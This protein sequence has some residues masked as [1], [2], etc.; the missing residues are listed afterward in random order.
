MIPY[1]CLASRCG[2]P[3]A[4]IRVPQACQLSPIE[5]LRLFT[6]PKRFTK[7]SRALSSSYPIS[8]R[9]SASQ[10]VEESRSEDRAALDLRRG[11]SPPYRDLDGFFLHHVPSHD[12]SRAVMV[13]SSHNWIFEEEI[14]EL[15]EESGYA[16]YDISRAA[17][18]VNNAD[19][20]RERVHMVYDDLNMTPH[21]HCVVLSSPK[22]AFA[23]R[24]ELSG[25]VFYG[26]CVQIGAFLWIRR[27]LPR[28]GAALKW[29]WYANSS[30]SFGHRKLRY[31]RTSPKEGIFDSF[32]EGRHVVFTNLPVFG[33]HT[34]EHMPHIDYAFAHAYNVLSMNKSNYALRKEPFRGQRRGM[35]DYEF[36]TR[37]EAEDICKLYNGTSFGDLKINVAIR[38]PPSRY[39][40]G[41]WDSSHN[42]A[43]DQ[44]RDLGSAKETNFESVWL[45]PC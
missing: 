19:S 1:R 4:I 30:P 5:P 37:E 20:V 41:S 22:A 34:Y 18:I 39:L 3:S 9:P 40:G 33:K 6:R 8:G 2:T 29:G 42:R 35:I 7:Q 44:P 12:R 26:D 36:E 23:A 32:R 10:N 27:P 43:H 16:V 38:R 11:Q 31:P 15:F 25:A 13:T 14:R 17:I 28:E 45:S 21:E 24:R